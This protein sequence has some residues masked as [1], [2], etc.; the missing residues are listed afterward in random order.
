MTLHLY[1]G[2][3]PD[4]GREVRFLQAETA[5]GEL[6]QHRCVGHFSIETGAMASSE[7]GF[8]AMRQR[9]A[10]KPPGSTGQRMY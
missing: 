7:G 5:I 9:D 4:G 2:I 1:L 8:R 3:T 10:M 6:V